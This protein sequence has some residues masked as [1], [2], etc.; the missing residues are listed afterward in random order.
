MT[1]RNSRIPRFYKLNRQERLNALVENGMLSSETATALGAG[2]ADLDFETAN[3]MIENAIGMLG[4]PM[5]VGLN[6]LIDG[7]DYVV[8]M[9][10]EEPS[11]LAAVSNIAKTVRECGGF[12]TRATE[13]VMIGQI[14]VVGCPDLEAGKAA[15]LAAKA[16]L[17]ERANACDETLL[18]FGGGARDIEVRI[19]NGGNYRDML[20]VH[21]LV[22]CRDA[23]GANLINTMAETLAPEIESLTGGSVYLRILSNLADQRVASA[24]CTIPHEMLAK[25]DF[26]GAD[27]AEGVQIA[28]EFAEADPYRA[29]THNK[30]V[31]NGVSSVCI[32]TGND[33]RAIESGAHAYAARSGQYGPLATWRTDETSLTGTI[34]IPIAVGIVGGTLKVHPT[35]QA[36]HEILNVGSANELGRVMA[37]VGLAQNL[38]ALKA[39]A[40]EGIQRGHMSLHARSVALAAGATP[41]NI[42]AVVEHLIASG[43]VRIENAQQLLKSYP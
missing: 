30:G 35:V 13:P 27:V 31:M 18:S 28:S 8:P 40:T 24:T 32:A 14:Q 2:K 12:E 21:L 41:E 11:V 42:D 4:L 37:A 10:I 5:G 19:L 16:E 36:A 3:H 20:V 1:E 7:K 23:M 15:V 39:L 29:A 25:K 34:S 33:W 26:S 38:A 17:L 22:D 6:F 43:D 9:A